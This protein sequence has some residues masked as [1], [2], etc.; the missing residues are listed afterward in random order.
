[1]AGGAADLFS[2]GAVERLHQASAGIPRVLNHLA[3]QALLEAM[4]RGL[5]A[6]DEASAAA[7][8]GDCRHRLRQRAHGRLPPRLQI[9]GSA[10]GRRDRVRL[11]SY[12]GAR[13]GVEQAHG[14]L[15]P[16]AHQ[17][18]RVTNR[19]AAERDDAL[20]LL[21]IDQRPEPGRQDGVDLRGNA[22]DDFVLGPE[23]RL[24]NGRPFVETL[25][26]RV[27]RVGLPSSIRCPAMVKCGPPVFRPASAK[28]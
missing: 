5:A 11:R 26:G 24:R 10:C 22:R 12:R 14:H 28:T 23:R 7:G 4:G 15:G 8:R 6:V 16:P 17:I 3:T 21:E 13:L 1:M 18:E 2:A 20:E 25:G 19:H 27:D 9:L